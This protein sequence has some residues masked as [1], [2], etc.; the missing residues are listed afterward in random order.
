MKSVRSAAN[1]APVGSTVWLRVSENGM[2]Y[3]FRL[4]QADILPQNESRRSAIVI[5][6]ALSGNAWTST[7][8]FKS[9]HRRTLAMARSSPKL[10]SATTMPAIRSRCA[11][12]R[13]AHFAASSSDSTLPNFVSAGPRATM[14]APAASSTPIMVRRP[15]SQ[16][17]SGKKPRLPTIRPRVMSPTCASCMAAAVSAAARL[18]GIISAAEI[19]RATA[20][21]RKRPNG[22]GLQPPRHRRI[23]QMAPT[24]TLGV[25]FGTN[26]VRAVVVGCGDGRTVGTLVFHYPSGDRASCSTRTTRTSP[27][28][29]RRTTSRGC[30]RRCAGLSRTPPGTR[31][32]RGPRD[33]HRRRH[34]RFDADTRRC[35]EPGARA[36]PEVGGALAAQAWLWKDH[37]G[38]EEAAAITRIAAE[39][40]PEYLAPSAGR[41]RPSGSG[42]RSGAV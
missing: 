6:P 1:S 37:T 8:T 35:A 33:R 14:S 27:A 12:N 36:R 42:R 5:L 4:L 29:T 34:H 32:L 31:V 30:A 16:R 20:T 21:T 23:G 13:S 41:T 40:A 28:R 26:S 39:H 3:C 38:A 2:P 24:F 9:A 25:D 22:F 19:V 7:G 10:G 15:E 18:C 11:L 17:W